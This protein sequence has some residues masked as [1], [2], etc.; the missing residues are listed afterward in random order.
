MSPEQARGQPTDQRTDVWAFGC[1]L[2]EMLCGRPAFKR[3]TIADTLAAVVDRE[4]DWNSLSPL[5]PTL[6]RL[7]KKCLAKDTR[8][9][10]R[11]IGDAA[12]DLDDAYIVSAP[13]EVLIRKKGNTLWV[14]TAAA[15]I[16]ESCRIGVMD[17]NKHCLV[18]SD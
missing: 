6:D 8:R 11:N 18:T 13:K 3:S 15:C 4:P 16:R 2:F 10:L 17:T 5:P 12:L 9:R 14:A 1:L 7:L